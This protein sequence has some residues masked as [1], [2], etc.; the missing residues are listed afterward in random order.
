[1][2][3]LAIPRPA[4]EQIDA[5]CLTI[6]DANGGFPDSD[7]DVAVAE[8]TLAV[9]KASADHT[10]AADHDDGG[11]TGAVAAGAAVV[12][13]RGEP[14]GESHSDRISSLLYF[15]VGQ[16]S[17]LTSSVVLPPPNSAFTQTMADALATY[18]MKI[19]APDRSPVVD[20][21]SGES[22]AC[23]LEVQ[24]VQH[25]RCNCSG[26]SFATLRSRIGACWHNPVM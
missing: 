12:P 3:Y 19:I 14:S 25:V 22:M 15:E 26:V 11:A 24:P 10:G 17:E 13:D 4:G 7:V 6:F 8:L 9:A 2:T 5:V 16:T 1:M 21:A 18:E 23:T 20:E